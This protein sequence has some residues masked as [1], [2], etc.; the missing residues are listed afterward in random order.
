MG[1][2]LSRGTS[3]TQDFRVLFGLAIGIKNC[4]KNSFLVLVMVQVELE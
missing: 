1:T 2:L 4:V 3:S